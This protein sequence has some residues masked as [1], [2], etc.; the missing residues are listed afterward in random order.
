MHGAG[1]GDSHQRIRPDQIVARRANEFLC[2]KNDQAEW[3]PEED[4]DSN[5]LHIPEEDDTDNL[6]L[7][8]CIALWNQ[9][10]F[11]ENV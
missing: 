1:L 9:N 7:I 2:V 3:L 4:V 11:V 8:D 6:P 5:G 10:P